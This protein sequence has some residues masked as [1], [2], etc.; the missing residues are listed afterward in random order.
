MSDEA[1]LVSVQLDV[2]SLE[3]SL[4]RGSSRSIWGKI[5][6]GGP[7]VNFPALQWWDLAAA[8]VADLLDA[9]RRLISRQSDHCEVS[10]FDGPYRV[11][12]KAKSA[13]V[14]DLELINDG[15]NLR[16]TV[17]IDANLWWQSIRIAAE[18]L[19]KSSDAQNWIDSDV[20]RIKSIL[21]RIDA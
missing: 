2:A 19:I 8:L 9:S 1:V 5:W 4:S 17:M 21:S 18:A 11:L 7:E 6:I 10:F 15:R 12:I 3:K 20:D 16:K 13:A 14:W